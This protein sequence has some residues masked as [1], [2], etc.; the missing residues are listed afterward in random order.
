M[1]GHQLPVVLDHVA[2]AEQRR[3]RNDGLHAHRQ[4]AQRTGQHA[5]H[6]EQRVAVDQ[7][8]VGPEALHRRVGPGGEHLRAVAVARQLGRAGGAAGVKVRGD[9]G[10]RKAP[11]A[12]QPVGGLGG[13]QGVE[14]EHAFGPGAR[15]FA[16]AGRRR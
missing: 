10:R 7:H 11:L 14:V 13:A 1:P 16:A 5:G 3:R 9:V 2:V 6:M 4:R 12:Q 15:P 8:V